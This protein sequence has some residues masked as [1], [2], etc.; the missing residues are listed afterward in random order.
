MADGEQDQIENAFARLVQASNADKPNQIRA[1]AIKQCCQT[2]FGVT[3]ASTSENE[4]KTIEKARMSGNLHERPT[5]FADK[6]ESMVAR[7]AVVMILSGGYHPPAIEVQN[8]EGVAIVPAA[9][10]FINENA[11]QEANRVAADIFQMFLKPTWKELSAESLKKAVSETYVG[12][13][14][15]IAGAMPIGDRHYHQRTAGFFQLAFEDAMAGNISQ[16]RMDE[17]RKDLEKMKAEMEKSTQKAQY[18][19]PQKQAH[20][21]PNPYGS[22]SGSSRKPVGR[23]FCFAWLNTAKASRVS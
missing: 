12:K 20:S 19:S 6:I 11:T 2:R 21:K 7:D 17:S 5:S 15:R 18:V 22:G 14:S 13:M 23:R 16:T 8:E 9:E 3:I 1:R 4:I 10:A